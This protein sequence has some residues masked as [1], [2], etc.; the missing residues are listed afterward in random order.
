MARQLWLEGVTDA[1]VNTIK[2]CIEA[3]PIVKDVVPLATGVSDAVIGSL[4]TGVRLAL[5]TTSAAGGLAGH[6]NPSLQTH[7]DVMSGK[8]AREE[9]QRATV[10]AGRAAG[11]AGRAL[12]AGASLASDFASFFTALGGFLG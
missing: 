6:L 9:Y 1:L 8:Q 10:S 5:G 2:G 7:H 4:D 12:G 11:G 3:T